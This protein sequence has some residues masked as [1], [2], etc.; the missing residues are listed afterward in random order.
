MRRKTENWT[1]L[2]EFAPWVEGSDYAHQ[3]IHILTKKLPH[4]VGEEEELC[5]CSPEFIRY[6]DLTDRFLFQHRQR[7]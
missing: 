4:I 1:E 6:D 3:T 7:H 5:W 2:P